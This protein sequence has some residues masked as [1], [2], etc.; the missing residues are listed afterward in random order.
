MLL[1]LTNRFLSTTGR[2]AE[3][4]HIWLATK[5]GWFSA[6]IDSHRTG[7]MLSGVD[8]V[9]IF[10]I[11][12]AYAATLSSMELPTFN[13]SRDYRWV[14]SISKTNWV[15]LALAVDYGSFMNEVA[16]NQGQANKREAYKAVYSAM[17]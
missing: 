1:R 2:K 6:V 14:M 9:P 16:K 13:E 4:N 5:I 17:Y 15:Q 8:V 10:S 12:I 7:H 3:F 11:C